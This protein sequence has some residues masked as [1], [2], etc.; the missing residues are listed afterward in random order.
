[1]KREGAAKIRL[2]DTVYKGD[3][4]NNKMGRGSERT[5]RR[6]CGKNERGKKREN[7]SN[8]G[9]EKERKRDSSQLGTLPPNSVTE[10][11]LNFTDDKSTEMIKIPVNI[12]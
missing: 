4:F 9:R 8:R 1:M 10:Q 5:S 11:L 6:Q 7:D 12:M 2:G 3:E